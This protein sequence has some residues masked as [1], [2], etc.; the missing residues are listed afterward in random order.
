[1]EFS[2]NVVE[3]ELF[4]KCFASISSK[5]MKHITGLPCIAASIRI[6]DR[7]E[8]IQSQYESTTWVSVQSG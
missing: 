1:M 5:G 6:V 4:E 2:R 3:N 8:I 7:G